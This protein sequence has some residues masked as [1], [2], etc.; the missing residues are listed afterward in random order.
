[1]LYKISKKTAGIGIILTNSFTVVI[2]LLVILKILPFD[3]IGGGRAESYQ[4]AYSTAITSII[5]I[6]IETAVIL[7][8]S[9]LIKY[10]R[11]KASIKVFLWMVFVMLCFN[12]IANLLGVTLFEKVVMTFIC[13]INIVLVMRLALDKG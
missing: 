9:G 2:E 11:F 10:K 8:A 4:A 7:V 5:I 13:L 3:I 6:I 1:M 12:V